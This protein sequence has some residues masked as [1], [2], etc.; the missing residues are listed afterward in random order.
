MGV[1]MEVLIV[2][3]VIVFMVYDMCKV[4][5]CVMMIMDI[6]LDEKSGG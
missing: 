6:R 2:V 1:E 3:M 5:D 4:V